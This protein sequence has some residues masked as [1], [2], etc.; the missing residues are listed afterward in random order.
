MSGRSSSGR[1][2]RTA[3]HLPAKGRKLKIHALRV[4]IVEDEQSGPSTPFDVDAFIR[5][6][7]RESRQRRT[8]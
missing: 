1:G 7:Q 4:A 6:K 8:L 2:H 5:C 3:S